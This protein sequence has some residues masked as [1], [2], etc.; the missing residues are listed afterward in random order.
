MNEITKGSI[1]QSNAENER[2]EIKKV[3]ESVENKYLKDIQNKAPV[4][5]IRF[6][7]IILYALKEK[8]D[9]ENQKPLTNYER[10]KNMS[11]DEMAEFICK[12][13]QFCGFENGG[14]DCEFGWRGGDCKDHTKQW[15]K[16]KVEE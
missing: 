8:L 16:S 4:E 2:E 11:V 7:E 12:G 1:L 6:N 13:K 9:R 14:I 5:N 10:I 15:L 3:F